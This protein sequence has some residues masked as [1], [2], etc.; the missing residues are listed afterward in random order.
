[1][2]EQSSRHSTARVLKNLLLQQPESPTFT[3]NSFNTDF[4]TGFK[5]IFHIVS[6]F[7]M[8]RAHFYSQ[9]LVLLLRDSS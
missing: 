9:T 4:K 5:L 3:R 8:W 7:R 6:F 2:L 1:M